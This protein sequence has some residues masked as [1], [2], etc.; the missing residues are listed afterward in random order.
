MDAPPERRATAP[1]AD[2]ARTPAS[3]G[4]TAAVGLGALAVF[5]AA[6][7][8]S[9]AVSFGKY[10]LA[11]ES[12]IDGT[13]PAERVVDFS[14]L[15][16]FLH[17]GTSALGFG[18]GAFEALQIGLA[19]L[20][21]ALLFALIHPRLGFRLAVLGAVVFA[22]DR[23]LLVYQ[24]VLEPEIVLL[25]A[26]LGFFVLLDHRTAAA[27]A[28][29][30][31]LAGLALLTRPTFLPIFLAVPLYFRW[32]APA[33]AWGRRSLAFLAPVAAA[34]ALLTLHVGSLRAPV[35]NPGTVFFEGNQPLSRGTSA[36][37]P[38]LVLAMVRADLATADSAHLHYRTVARAAV[39]G[40]SPAAVNG[41]WSARARSFL[42]DEPAAAAARFQRKLRY[43]L[44][45]YRWHDV[46]AADRHDRRMPW[47]SLPFSL[48]STLALGG[49]IA[50][51]RRWRG[52]LPFYALFAVQMAVMLV[53]YVSM[54]Q[55][56][57]L[58]PAIV[59][60]AAVALGHLVAAR[61]KGL[62][63]LVIA[64]LTLSLTL[65]DDAMRDDTYQQL[66]YL[67]A[68]PKLAAIERAEGPL[69]R[70]REAIV[71]AMASMP[72]WSDWIRPAF[73]P[74]DDRTLDARVVERLLEAVDRAPA[75]SRASLELDLARALVDVG[76]LD[77]ARPRLEALVEL[78]FRAYRGSRM[79]SDPRIVLAE[80]E[81]RA[82]DRGRARGL[83]EAGLDA[84]PANPFAL[85]A[86]AALDPDAETDAVARLDRYLGEPDRRWVYGRTLIRFGEPRRAAAQLA[87]L[88]DA[89][90][91]VRAVKVHFALAS[92]LAGDLDRAVDALVEANAI[93][94]EP[95][96]A[97]ERMATVIRRW[98]D[99]RPDDPAAQVRAAELLHQHGFV[100]DAR[101]RLDALDPSALSP[102]LA[103]RV[104][105]ARRAFS[106]L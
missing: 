59:C 74:Q 8:L 79:P 6:A 9:P 101:R 87:P 91:T 70:Q 45:A 104:A 4:H 69:S 50:G 46:P 99:R 100:G 75:Y 10:T 62:I 18:P 48:L 53:F 72:W 23:H 73:V 52:L 15:Y 12:W 71:D 27:A 35:M 65:P 66:G 20:C 94:V 67:E 11:A 7:A 25:S 89:F 103:S 17:V 40:A 29:A 105:A 58:L 68:G 2:D 102:D 49:L 106:V 92:G 96:I 84:S 24:R 60:F 36:V 21:V 14:P 41:A 56:L 82:G 88:V 86:L 97:V 85:A 76:R 28:G 26:L 63:A 38:P 33:P 3:P 34:A 43:A 47:P 64:V 83:I 93:H 16:L 44:H 95:V 78:D 98:A 42:V 22:L 19:A 54:R 61:R 55:R 30:G 39:P 5:V 90:P 80:L 57:V 51:A 13:F 37:Y 32:L 77:E 31:V 81:T 1:P